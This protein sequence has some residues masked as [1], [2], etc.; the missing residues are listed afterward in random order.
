M[1]TVE[2]Y[3]SIT[4]FLT[5]YPNQNRISWNYRLYTCKNPQPCYLEYIEDNKLL[6]I[7]PTSEHYQHRLEAYN[8]KKGEQA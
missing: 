5:A 6:H 1:P 8:Q 3:N 7:Y 2:E 4:E